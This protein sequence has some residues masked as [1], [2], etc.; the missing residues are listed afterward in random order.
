MPLWVFRPQL[1]FILKDKHFYFAQ[2]LPANGPLEAEATEPWISKIY[3]L[4]RPGWAFSV[5]W[6]SSVTAPRTTFSSVKDDWG[7]EPRVQLSRGP[8]SFGGRKKKKNE[9]G[10]EKLLTWIY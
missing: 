5:L 1:G 10:G 6:G 9:G 4:S 7:T 3:M 2:A 8:G